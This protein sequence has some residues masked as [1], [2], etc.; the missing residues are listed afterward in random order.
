MATLTITTP[1]GEDATIAANIGRA[2]GLG[3]S[4]TGPEIKAEM[5]RHMKALNKAGAESIAN[6]VQRASF[7]DIT[8]T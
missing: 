2:L 5:V 1:G 3:R 6:D 7:V 4:A 8:P